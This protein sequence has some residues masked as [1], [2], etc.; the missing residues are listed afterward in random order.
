M[1][2][3]PPHTLVDLQKK[4]LG[5]KIKLPDTNE[6]TGFGI[7]GGYI[8]GVCNS[9]GYNKNFPSWGLTVVI[10]RMP[11]TNVDHT[12]IELVK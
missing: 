7:K 12:K 8:S 1:N 5:K 6:Y 3:L 4:F 10:N 9:T 2:I 11:I